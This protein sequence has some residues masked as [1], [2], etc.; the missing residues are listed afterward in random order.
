M[1]LPE[2]LV[3]I[4]VGFSVLSSGLGD[5]FILVHGLGHAAWCWYKIIPLLKSAGHNVTAIDLA[6]SGS[7]PR[8]ILEIHT[9]AQYNEPLTNLMASIPDN[10]TVI[11]V[12]HSLGGMN[13]AFAMEQFTG[14][15]SVAV[16][17]NALLPDT[18]HTPDYVMEQQIALGYGPASFLDTVFIPY[19]DP[20]E[21]N[22][23]FR[24]GPL[25]L[26]IYL[27]NESPAKDYT[28]ATILVRAGNPFTADLA[29]QPK[30]TDGGFGSVARVYITCTED[31]SEPPPFQLYMINNTGVNQV[32][33][34]DGADHMAML[35]KPQQ[36][37][38]YLLNVSATFN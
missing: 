28:L 12:G 33:Q 10:E 34:I 7:D 20:Q 32:F 2:Q 19:P 18:V 24:F 38:N 21:N 25:F 9:F 37:Y 5:H 17:L 8:S 26:K 27:Y 15:I 3:L 16:F 35:S 1:L 11:L 36:V 13:I 30:F 23:A 14:K 6:A 22:T 31:R 4:L 29:K